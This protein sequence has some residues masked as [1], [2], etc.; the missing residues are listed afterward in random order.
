M[1]SGTN[2]TY[3][4]LMTAFMPRPIQSEAQFW[5]TQARIDVLLDKDDLT[6]DEQDY[7]TMLG[8]V[9]E[10]YEDDNEPDFELRGAALIKALNEEH[11]MNN[12]QLDLQEFEARYQMSSETFY[13]QFGQGILDDREDFIIWSGLYELLLGNK[14]QSQ[15]SNCEA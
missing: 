1:I 10:R 12:L 7:L 6:L 13:E 14:N 8:L 9:I 11:R 4:Q 3:E 15:S 5:E 2:L